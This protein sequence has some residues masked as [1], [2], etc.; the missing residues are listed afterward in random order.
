MFLRKLGIVVHCCEL[1]CHAE[2][3]RKKEEEKKEK[4]EEGCC[5]LCPLAPLLDNNHTVSYGGIYSVCTK[6]QC[7]GREGRPGQS[8]LGA[9]KRQR[10]TGPGEKGWSLFTHLEGSRLEQAHEIRP[11][12]P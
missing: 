6:R 2:K 9:G 1:E 11:N 10:G 4:K 5:L 7:L 3:K 12:C 8:K